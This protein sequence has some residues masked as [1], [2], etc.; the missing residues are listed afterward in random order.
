M[1]LLL[2]AAA[3]SGRG[4]KRIGGHTS[5]FFCVWEGRALVPGGHRPAPT[6]AA[7][8]NYGPCNPLKVLGFHPKPHKPFEK[9]LSENFTCLH[10]TQARA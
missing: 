4:G 8:E 3:G 1:E 9:G 10:P 7:A 5:P 6:E 2:Q